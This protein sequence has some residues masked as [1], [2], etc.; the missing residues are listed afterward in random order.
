MTD[1]Q[2]ISSKNS[3]SAVISRVIHGDP[4]PSST[5]DI[6]GNRTFKPKIL[7]SLY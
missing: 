7:Q 6:T 4:I 2:K 3:T 1:N 5:D